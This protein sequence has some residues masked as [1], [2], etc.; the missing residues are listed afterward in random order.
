LAALRNAL[1]G[2]LLDEVA[3][4]TIDNFIVRPKRL[5]VEKYQQ[6][7]AWETLGAE[8]RAELCQHVA[9]LPSAFDDDELEAKQ[10]DRLI[11]QTQLA[12]LRA[13]AS[14]VRCQKT[15]RTL[16]AALEELN[17]VP[18]VAAEMELILEIQT[19]DF[20][21]GITL[22]ML[23]TARRRLRR[24]IKIIERQARKIVYTDFEDEIGS[25]TT[26]DLLA[27]GPGTDK[28]RFRAKVRHFLKQHEDHIT[29][30]KLRRNE[31]LTPQDLVEL[32][33][34]FRDEGIAAD[35]DLERIKGEMG[36]LG[37]FIRSLVGLDREA[38]KLALN[39]FIEGRTANQIE[40]VD[41]IIDHLTERG[42]MEP[43]L[44]YEAPFTDFDEQGVNGVFSFDEA[45]KLAQALGD[46]RARAAA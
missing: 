39:E 12:M 17:N 34:I 5:Y 27:T 1:K 29:L 33:R 43:S 23:E 37:L 41:M 10:F 20:W 11:L 13:D 3:G 38:A 36:G 30:L 31:Q 26:I 25:G 44:L 6:P 18:M 2:R 40:F 46:I 4:M 42:T 35:D 15:I 16:A 32:E 9:G 21:E 24:L 28:A 19:D 14:F 8:D 7:E 45:K 22:P